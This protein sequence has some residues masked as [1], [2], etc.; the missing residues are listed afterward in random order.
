MHISTDIHENFR[1][2][3]DDKETFKVN[4]AGGAT[5]CLTGIASLELN[6]DDQG[7]AHNFIASQSCNNI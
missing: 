1:Q 4:T 5:L 6:T 7:F 3:K 2:S